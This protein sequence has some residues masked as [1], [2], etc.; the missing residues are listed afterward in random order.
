MTKSHKLT[1]YLVIIGYIMSIIFGPQKVR[2]FTCCGCST[3]E[4]K[5]S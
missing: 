2:L 1:E 5:W 3:S 4:Y